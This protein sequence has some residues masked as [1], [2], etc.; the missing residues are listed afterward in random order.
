MLQCLSLV[1][2]R[3]FHKPVEDTLEC[4]YQRGKLSVL[5]IAVHIANT[6]A[7]KHKEALEDGEQSV[8]AVV[9]ADDIERVPLGQNDRSEDRVYRVHSC[10]YIGIIEKCFDIR[11]K[12]TSFVYRHGFEYVFGWY[13]NYSFLPIRQK[14]ILFFMP[15]FLIIHACVT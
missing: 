5:L 4:F 11:E 14:T 3:I 7:R 10:C 12:R 9:P 2:V 6:K 1:Y 13:L 8:D 15:I